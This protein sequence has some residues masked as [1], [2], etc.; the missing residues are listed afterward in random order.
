MHKHTHIWRFSLWK[1]NGWCVVVVVVSVVY[2]SMSRTLK[3]PWTDVSLW[4]PEAGI[5][6]AWNIHRH[7]SKIHFHFLLLSGCGCVCSLKH[8]HYI[9][10]VTLKLSEN[11][12]A[13]KTSVCVCVCVY[14]SC[15]TVT[16][17]R[18]GH[19]KPIRTL[20][21]HQDCEMYYRLHVNN[22]TAIHEMCFFLNTPPPFPSLLSFSIPVSEA[23]KWKW[24]GDRCRRGDLFS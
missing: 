4:M 20:H 17:N 13:I 15:S 19:Y 14:A 1:R 21:L 3:T 12:A 9:Q 8:R 23:H 22:I 10:A 7:P 6:L 18:W 16:I 24:K 2:S 5:Q 11:R